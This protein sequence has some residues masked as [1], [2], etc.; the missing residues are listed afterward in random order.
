MPGSMKHAWPRMRIEE[1]PTSQKNVP[2]G[3]ENM[4]R[5]MPITNNPV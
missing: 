1:A 4:S 2:M 5:G 3:E